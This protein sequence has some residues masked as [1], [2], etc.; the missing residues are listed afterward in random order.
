MTGNLLRVT[1]HVTIPGVLTPR[2]QNVDFPKAIGE[3]TS[4]GDFAS[5]YA[6][7]NTIDTISANTDLFKQYG[8]ASESNFSNGQIEV[9]YN[10]IWA[11]KAYH[12]FQA[13]KFDALGYGVSLDEFLDNIC[14]MGINQR[15]HQTTL[16]GT[17]ATSTQGLVRMGTSQNLPADS[18]TNTSITTYIVPEL[19]SFLTGVVQTMMDNTYNQGKPTVLWSST[20]VINYLRRSIIPLAQYQ[21]EGAGVDS[22]AGAYNRVVGEWLGIGQIIFLADDRLKGAGTG[23]A[24]LIGFIAPG[25]T[26]DEMEKGTPERFDQTLNKLLGNDKNTFMSVVGGRSFYEQNPTKDM[27]V[28]GNYYMKA[29]PGVVLRKD[30]VTWVTATY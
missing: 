3:L 8:V 19:L 1:P 5:D 30:A 16:F 7:L 4:I 22:V 14:V 10:T 28:S 15:L 6:Y 12:K 20:R 9:P 26:P 2:F 23:G 13:D 25:L 17:D 21:M 29:T 27:I 18:A 24:D 11:R